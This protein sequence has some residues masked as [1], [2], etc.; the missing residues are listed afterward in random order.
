MSDIDGI[1]WE[2]YDGEE[3]APEDDAA[4]Y[5]RQQNEKD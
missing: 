1:D 3:L 2:K 4:E 5:E